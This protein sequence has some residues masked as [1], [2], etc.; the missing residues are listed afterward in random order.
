MYLRRTLP[1]NVS[2]PSTQR[3]R[4]VIDKGDPELVAAVERAEIAVSAAAKQI[5]ANGHDD[6]PAEPKQRAANKEGITALKAKLVEANRLRKL[7]GE[8]IRRLGKDLTNEVI[9]R[10]YAD[11]RFQK[12]TADACD[13]I[14]DVETPDG[15]SPAEQ[16]AFNFIYRASQAIG[17]GKDN[18]FEDAEAHEITVSILNAAQD[19]ASVWTDLVAALN[20][21]RPKKRG[22]GP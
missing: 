6:T 21:R 17:Y 10:D 20:K 8:E 4:K 3:A 11:R 7:S 19:A 5:E 12:L 14:P 9:M 2:L 18:G 22:G 16:R 1:M 13:E 15:T